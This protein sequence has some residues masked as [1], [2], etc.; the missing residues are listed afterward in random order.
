MVSRDATTAWSAAAVIFDL[1]GTLVDSDAALAGAFEVL[2][3]ASEDITY[4][5]VLAAECARLGLTVDAY[6]EAYDTELVRPYPGVADMLQVI[7]RWALC[8]NKHP[9][10]GRAELARLGWEPEV[11]LFADAFDGPKRLDPALDALGL[12]AEQVVFVGDT[13]HDRSAALAIGCRFVWAGWN[14]RIEP[15]R[16]DEVAHDPDHLITLVRH[17]ASG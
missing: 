16:G 10:S 17:H 11:A 5:H 4:G 14:P 13:E 1:D 8:S 9:V 12:D 7:G 2:G 15:R 3:V 6:L